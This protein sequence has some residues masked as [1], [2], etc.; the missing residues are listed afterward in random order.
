[1]DAVVYFTVVCFGVVFFPHIIY[2]DIITSFHMT[3]SD[4]YWNTQISN[5]T[6]LHSKI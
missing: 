1:M 5:S 6:L 3:G 4:G 2:K